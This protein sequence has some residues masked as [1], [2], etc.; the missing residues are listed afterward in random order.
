MKEE[1]PTSQELNNF[2]L[3]TDIYTAH[4]KGQSKAKTSTAAKP[5]TDQELLLLLEALEMYKVSFLRLILDV[6]VAVC[7]LGICINLFMVT[8]RLEQSI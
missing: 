4:I 3:K 6:T 2:G 1:K 7:H 8:G 5:W